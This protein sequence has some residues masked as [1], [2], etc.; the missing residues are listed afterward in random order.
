M[1]RSYTLI[2][3]MSLAFG[4]MAQT[5]MLSGVIASPDGSTIPGADV[6]LPTLRTGTTTDLLGRYQITGIPA[7]EHLVVFSMMGHE[8]QEMLL[9]FDKDIVQYRRLEMAPI[10]LREVNIRSRSSAGSEVIQSLDMRTRP[11]NTSQDLLTLVPG[12]FIAQHAGGGKAEQIFYRGFDIDHGTDLYITVDG[13]PVNMVSH[14]HGQGYADLHFTIPETMEKLVLHKGPYEARF[15]DFATSG[16]VEFKTRNSLDRNLL[17]VE[18]GMFNTTRV[19]S[20]FDI[21]GKKNLFSQRKET[22]YIA[23]EYAYTDAYFQSEQHFGRFNVFGKYTGELSERTQLTL[24]GSTFGASWDASG[25][26]PVRAVE[27]G[28]IDRFG[29]IDDTEGGS[30]SRTNAYATLVTG[31]SNGSSFKNQIYFVKYDFNL[32]S[33]FTFFAEDSV[34]GDMIAQTDD[35]MIMGYTGTYGWTAPVAG[36]NVKFNSGIGMRHDR[37]DISLKNAVQRV[38]YD[39]IVAGSVEQLNVNAYI[40]ATYP[41]T[42]KLSMNSAARLDVFSFNYS[43]AQGRDTLGGNALQHRVSPKLSFS[44]SVS[45]RTEI[46]LRNGIGFH[47][48]D[49]RAVVLGQAARTLPRAYGSDLGTTF[50][51]TDRMLANF[52]LWGLY[53]ENE[54]VYVGDAG[55][56]ETSDPTRRVGI[57]LS[58]RYQLTKELFADIDV[59]VVN[60][61]L[62]GPGPGEDRIPLAPE[63]T[64]IGGLAYVKECGFN[65]SLR[66]RC[67]ADRPA[68]EDNSIVAEGFVLLDAVASYRFKNLEVGATIENIMDVEWNQAQ[69]A[70]ESRLPFETEA[71]DELHYTPGTPRFIRGFASYRF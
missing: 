14:A 70:T 18:H 35:R 34:R 15:G 54:L 37:A 29:A 33:N 67:I 65:A 26:I 19:V 62:I 40:D 4:G 8:R 69:F 24:S 44:Y 53:L 10:E 1:L 58:L 68:N 11:V 30:T 52:A 43:D 66:Y 25:Q 64:T 41:L 38:V 23:G 21:L 20:M 2:L 5:H 45:D 46:Y 36:R 48:N 39:T 50:K 28:L 56:V 7:G 57:D 55:V 32:Y 42:E 6:Y 47:S 51:P 60:A 59:N 31:L 9:N 27:S 63:F 12:L 16:T 61:R 71:V 22:A 49:A 17:K 13:M 3:L